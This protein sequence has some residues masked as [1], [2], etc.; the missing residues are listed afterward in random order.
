MYAF[1]GIDA[2]VIHKLPWTECV[3]HPNCIAAHNKNNRKLNFED[4]LSSLGF[5]VNAIILWNTRYIELAL[6]TL[7]GDGESIEVA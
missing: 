5:V 3:E 1:R 6:D 2:T 4:Q 7:R